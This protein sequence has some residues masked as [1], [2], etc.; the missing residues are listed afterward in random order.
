[1]QFWDTSALVPLFV[2]QSGS[3][4]VAELDTDAPRTVWTLTEV[5]MRAAL[6]RLERAGH[7]TAEASVA[8][9]D[10]FEARRVEWAIVHAMEPVKLR[11][12][13]V[14]A[15]HPLGSADALQ[16]A[17]ALVACEDR[18][19]SATFVTLDER[20]AAA[21]RRE[22]FSVLPRDAGTAR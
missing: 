19:T 7:L 13:R 18:P 3:S 5:E 2:K 1:V 17:A 4:R 6:A 10:A 14:L 20:Q 11:A 15:F 21:A 16:L 8:A 9:W 22:G 12:R